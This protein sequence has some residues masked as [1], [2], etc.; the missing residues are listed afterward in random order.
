MAKRC[1]E[2][3]SGAR[4]VD[5]ILTHSL[6]PAASAEILTRAAAGESFSNVEVGVDDS[7]AFQIKV[8]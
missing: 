1:T 6:L 4:A 7:G 3:E 2:S 5:H 8:S